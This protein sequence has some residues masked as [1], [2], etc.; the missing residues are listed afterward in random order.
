MMRSPT[1]AF[2]WHE[3]RVSWSAAVSAGAASAL[4][5]LFFSKYVHYGEIASETAGSITVAMLF[6]LA[7]ISMLRRSGGRESQTMPRYFLTLPIRSG[8]WSALHF[9]YGVCILAILASALAALHLYLFGA[10]ARF[11][12]G[13]QLSPW[14]FA[15]CIAAFGALLEGV[16][17]LA[18]SAD[19]P[20]L[21]VAALG[22]ASV[23]FAGATMV[24]ADA[25]SK[26]AHRRNAAQMLASRPPTSPESG[27]TA[28]S[29]LARGRS[30]SPPAQP[31]MSNEEQIARQRAMA[32]PTLD[33]PRVKQGNNQL[34][35]LRGRRGLSQRQHLGSRPGSGSAHV[36]AGFSLPYAVWAWG[37][38]LILGYVLSHIGTLL[39]RHGRITV[40]TEKSELVKLFRN[41]KRDSAFRSSDDAAIWF[42]WRRFGKY[43]PWAA[44]IIML[45]CAPVYLDPRNRDDIAGLYAGFL[46]LSAV[47]LGTYMTI[48][49]HWDHTSGFNAFIFT[50]PISTHRLASARLRMS[51]RSVLV[52]LLVVGVGSL[53]FVVP[54]YLDYVLRVHGPVGIPVMFLEFAPDAFVVVASI[55]A[56]LL[57][58]LWLPIPTFYAAMGLLLTIGFLT[59]ALGLK[60]RNADYATGMVIVGAVTLASLGTVWCACRS[61]LLL[62]SGWLK[63]LALSSAAAC[64]FFAYHRAEFVWPYDTPITLCLLPALVLFSTVPFASVPLSIKWYRH[65]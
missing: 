29:G 57:I 25:D 58:A 65:R 51:L 20:I 14:M 9:G 15:L 18:G 7:I 37:A 19:S 35:E 39:H 56:A 48:R 13:F 3:W 54:E 34:D 41:R 4:A 38:L 43:L 21:T 10:Q 11:A 42:E 45:C 16:F 24:A 52:S 5:M 60:D 31:G 2:L 1:T 61:G 27:A 59:T 22:A 36:R 47:G 33:E 64:T 28:T 30:P 46:G 50:L 26:Q 23:L 49:H 12:L 8:F 53:V 62:G 63:M 32:R 55:L 6:G 17:L 40:K 44:C